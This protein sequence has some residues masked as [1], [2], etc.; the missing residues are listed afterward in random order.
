M[1]PHVTQVHKAIMRES[2]EEARAMAQPQPPDVSW[3]LSFD[4][5]LDAVVGSCEAPA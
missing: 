2:G 3:S 5:A 4:T 1:A